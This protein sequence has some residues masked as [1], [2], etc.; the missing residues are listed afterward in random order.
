MKGRLASFT[1]I[2]ATYCPA[3]SPSLYQGGE[4]CEFGLIDPDGRRTVDWHLW[5]AS[6]KKLLPAR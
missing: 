3:V 1:P 2:R 5:R 6:S 4:L